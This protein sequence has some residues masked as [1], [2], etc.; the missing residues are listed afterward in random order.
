MDDGPTSPLVQ[1]CVENV[2][3]LVYV[4]GGGFPHEGMFAQVL[5]A[6]MACS[7]GDPSGGMDDDGADDEDDAGIVFL[8]LWN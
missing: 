2:S 7:D 8:T 6:D 1:K 3:A 5:D 4:D